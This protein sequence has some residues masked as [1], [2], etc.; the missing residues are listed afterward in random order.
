[1][2]S[3]VCVSPLARKVYAA[4]FHE[5]QNRHA[6]AVSRL[7]NKRHSTETSDVRVFEDG[8]NESK[9]TQNTLLKERFGKMPTRVRLCNQRK[10]RT[11]Q[12]NCD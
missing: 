10:R 1:M 4:D 12:M 2:Y 3:C 9:H 7:W 11:M 5:S 8:Q 6:P